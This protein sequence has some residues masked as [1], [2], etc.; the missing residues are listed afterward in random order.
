MPKTASTH[1]PASDLSPEKPLVMP[2]NGGPGR[3]R[4]DGPIPYYAQLA[5]ILEQEIAEGKWSPGQELPSEADL[6]RMHGLSRTAVRQAV[7]A[8]AARGL[9]RKEKGRRTTV[10][11]SRVTNLVVQELRGFY[12]E[13]TERGGSVQTTI[14]R[15]ELTQAPPQVA[16]DLELPAGGD[17]VLV[18]RLRAVDGERIVYV[19]TSLPAPRFAG[20]LGMDLSNASLYAVLA[21]T[22]GV[23]PR[24]GHRVI[25]AA[26]ADA[27]LAG[28][29][30]L[31]NGSPVLQLTALNR[32]ENGTPFESWQAWYRGDETRFE[33]IVGS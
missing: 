13:M 25:E 19:E 26:T 16:E 32:D 10:L 23:H 17:V 1:P 5:R 2:G 28:H 27:D 3:V 24:S 4:R 22:F 30:Q 15:Q 33:L 11:R 12:D 14:L 29:L 31:P 20:L 6:C 9:V 18:S 21:E 7:A 8:L